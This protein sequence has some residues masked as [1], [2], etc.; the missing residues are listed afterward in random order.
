MILEQSIFWG[1][2]CLLVGVTALTSL[3]ARKR[4]ANN[5]TIEWIA[6][7]GD[8]GLVALAASIISTMIGGAFFVA[9]LLL[10]HQSGIV[11]MYI[12]LAYFVGL[13]L[14]GL[15]APRILKALDES[16]SITILHFVRNRISTRVGRLFAAI[17]TALFV[18][19]I[20]VQVLAISEYLASFPKIMPGNMIQFATISVVFVLAF[21]YTYFGGLRKDIYSD[22][23]QL[24]FI[25]FGLLIIAY[26]AFTD[27]TLSG[28]KNLDPSMYTV[29][30]IGVLYAILIMLLIVPML[31]VRV[32][33]WQR[34]RAARSPGVASR[35]LYIS[36]VVI[37]LGFGLFTFV[38]MEARGAGL[39]GPGMLNQYLKFGGFSDVYV[40]VVAIAFL[41]A[42][43]SSL[44]SLLNMASISCVE[45]YKILPNDESE[46]NSKIYRY[47]ITIISIIGIF[48]SFLFGD[49]VN[50]FVSVISFVMVLCPPILS[51]LFLSEA[52]ERGSFWS[53]I[54]GSLILISVS[55]YS[56]KMAFI[57]AAFAGW[58]V[59][60]FF[61]YVDSRNKRHTSR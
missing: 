4:A 39:S 33:L 11:G 30:P 51:L 53:I 26:T 37:G 19:T 41:G 10:G 7:G 18:L 48:I 5:Q 54:V 45:M 60:L 61:S 42:V 52:S 12:G 23:A 55:F 28:L 40:T 50:L 16:Q 14:L 8:V 46:N 15:F 49:I 47:G 35:A 24:L 29:G 44:D 56:P 34:I 3:L 43:I 13:V 59:Y 6:A 32:D 57:P 9:I 17:C 22:I 21:V 38:G 31:L 27:L 2:L 20:A 58:L 36:A 25:S 1:G